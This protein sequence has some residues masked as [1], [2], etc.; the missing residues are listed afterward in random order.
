MKRL[1]LLMLMFIRSTSVHHS[2]ITSMPQTQSTK[3][4]AQVMRKKT[5]Y[6]IISYKR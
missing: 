2:H 1:I 4:R 3:V 5:D 6:N